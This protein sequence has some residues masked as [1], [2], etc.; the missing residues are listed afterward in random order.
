[1]DETPGASRRTPLPS[2][3]I[4][5]IVLWILVQTLQYLQT[6]QTDLPPDFG[7]K[8]AQVLQFFYAYLLPVV[9]AHGLLRRSRF[10]WVIA[11]AWQGLQAGFGFVDLLLGGWSWDVIGDFSG[12]YD[13]FG[14]GGSSSFY[15]GPFPVIVA[16]VSA[17]LLLAPPTRR[18][19]EES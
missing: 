5:L 10:I 13:R 8:L 3:L 7:F 9:I 1:M 18:W 6:R 15:D 12:N 16:V 19:L 14:P 4:A 11:F 2:T 17:V